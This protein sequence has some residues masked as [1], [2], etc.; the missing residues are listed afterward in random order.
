MGPV[1]LPY[2]HIPLGGPLILS[3]TGTHA[4]SE[5]APQRVVTLILDGA[6]AA[7]HAFGGEQF[8]LLRNTVVEIL[9]EDRRGRV[10]RQQHVQPLDPTH[11]R[12]K[13]RLE[14]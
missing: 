11:H 8:G 9:L 4:K 12:P 3:R 6:Q 14:G 10:G 7:V 2:L 1:F 5:P 13:T